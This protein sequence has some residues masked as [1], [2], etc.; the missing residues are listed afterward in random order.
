MSKKDFKIISDLGKGAFAKVYRAVHLPTNEEVAI[1]IC[2]RKHLTTPRQRRN[3]ERE[4]R[5]M[6]LLHH[7]N[8]I[9]VR[10]VRV[11]PD[12]YVI[13]MQQARGGELFDLILKSN[14]LS[15]VV[16]R[17]Y[18]RQ[19]ASAL[20]YCHEHSIIHRDLKPENIL[21]DETHKRAFIIDFGFGNTYRADNV[22]NTFCGSPS[23]ASPEM[24]RGVPYVGP[25]LGV[26]LYAM[27]TGRLP[28]P[29][30]DGKQLCAQVSLGKFNI[31][32]YI[33]TSAADLL[34]RMLH[35]DPYKRA[36][37]PEILQ[38][39]WTMTGYSHPVGVFMLIALYSCRIPMR[40]VFS[41]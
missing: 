30:K 28:F 21:L 17:R 5:I 35:V 7:P 29:A 10:E 4:V 3:A 18:F 34:T 25:E 22:I 20:R 19:I 40:I 6:T 9:P 16:A 1:K 13:V 39:P 32:D 2:E 36:T 26:I 24:L 33:S 12:R 14:R 15:E 41:S 38:H 11:L 8:I 23:Y 37:M 31:P 27:L